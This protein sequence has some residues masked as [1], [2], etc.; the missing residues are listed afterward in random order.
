MSLQIF[1]GIHP[2]MS[3]PEVLLDSLFVSIE[4]R[5]IAHA[6]ACALPCILKRAVEMLPIEWHCVMVFS[7]KWI[8]IPGSRPATAVTLLDLEA[9]HS[10]IEASAAV[11]C[12]GL[13]FR[14]QCHRTGKS[15]WSRI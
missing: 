14:A 10:S 6:L 1:F 7:Q 9:K 8:Y 13:L 5:T 15:N 12:K 11:L 3:P 4:L 2:A